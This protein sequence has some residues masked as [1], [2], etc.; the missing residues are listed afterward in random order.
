M[1]DLNA[2]AARHLRPG[3]A[4][5]RLAVGCPTSIKVCR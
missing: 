5:V 3:T 4:T 2:L 1:R